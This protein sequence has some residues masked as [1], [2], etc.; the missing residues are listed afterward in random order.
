MP[1]RRSKKCPKTRVSSR[2]KRR[3]MNQSSKRR[4]GGGKG[5][6][7]EKTR[8]KKKK[9]KK[10]KKEKNKFSLTSYNILS[11]EFVYHI[12]SPKT[13]QPEPEIIRNYRYNKII[14]YLTKDS[15]TISL[16][17]EVEPFLIQELMVKK[18]HYSFSVS[19]SCIS[20]YMIKGMET[21]A[22]NQLADSHR[23]KLGG[24]S[25]SRDDERYLLDTW[26]SVPGSSTTTAI[27]WD[28]N[29][30]KKIEEYQ[31]CD[32]T[33][34]TYD[35]KN[36]IIVVLQEKVG[37]KHLILCSFHLSGKGNRPAEDLLNA[38]SLKMMEFKETYSD[39]KAYMGGDSN[40]N[41]YDLEDMRKTFTEDWSIMGVS[42]TPTVCNHDYGVIHEP[43][44]IDFILGNNDNHDEGYKYDVEYFTEDCGIRPSSLEIY[45]RGN[46][47]SD[48]FPVLI[49][50][51]SF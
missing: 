10:E 32:D 37:G 48:H 7:S 46:S 23:S 9:E 25:G 8:G 17:Q 6:S 19:N 26:L 13:R 4:N 43:K 35:G 27:I 47:P 14:D 41:R 15:S 1:R 49:S 40:R 21:V 45:T 31:V 11:S 50:D 3:R 33:Y 29:I 30:Y 16:L 24:S 34:S 20:R 28:T 38:I 36:A 44:R 39:T 42:E 5:K 2:T 51:L 22:M 18:P 12:I